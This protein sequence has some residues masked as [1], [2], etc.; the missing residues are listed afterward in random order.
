MDERTLGYVITIGVKLQADIL[1]LVNKGLK[2]FSLEF[3]YFK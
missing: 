1:K 2:Y 3:S